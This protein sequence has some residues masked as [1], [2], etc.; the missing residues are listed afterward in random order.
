MIM[1]TPSEYYLKNFFL[2]YNMMPIAFKKS[3]KYLCAQ[4]FFDI[5]FVFLK[6]S[7]TNKKKRMLNGQKIR[8]I[9]RGFN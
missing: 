4:K 2:K 8:I 5:S 3:R 6:I 9:I 7:Q 1:Y